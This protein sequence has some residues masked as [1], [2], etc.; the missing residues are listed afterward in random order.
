[1][2]LFNISRLYTS[3]IQLRPK[4]LKRFFFPV[5]HTQKALAAEDPN[6]SQRCSVLNNYKNDEAQPI[7]HYFT[8]YLAVCHMKLTLWCG[9]FYCFCVS[10]E[11]DPDFNRFI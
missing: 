6:S 11:Q 9:I 2:N 4:S 3:T 1:M 5:G 8:D 10:L 7:L